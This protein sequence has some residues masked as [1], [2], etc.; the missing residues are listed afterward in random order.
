MGTLLK[1]NIVSTHTIMR[2]SMFFDIFQ[3]LPHF[4]GFWFYCNIR[5]GFETRCLDSFLTVN[6][7][8]IL[9]KLRKYKNIHFHFACVSKQHYPSVFLLITVRIIKF[10]GFLLLE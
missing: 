1:I 10:F 7:I 2:G 3:L 8:E 6:N 5:P 9:N 4:G